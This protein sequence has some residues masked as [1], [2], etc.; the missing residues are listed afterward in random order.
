[1]RQL[2]VPVIAKRCPGNESIVVHMETGLLY[3]TPEEFIKL[4]KLLIESSDLSQKLCLSAFAL[5]KERFTL[6]N[7]KT[8]YI[9]LFEELK[10]KN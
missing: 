8:L 6:E 4:A 10:K 1:M 9:K 3:D 2:Q 5:M 7:E